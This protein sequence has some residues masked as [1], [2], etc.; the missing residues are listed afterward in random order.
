MLPV[1]ALKFN[2]T[3]PEAFNFITVKM[4]SNAYIMAIWVVEFSNGVY[5]IR[6]CKVDFFIVP[7]FLMPK[8]K[9]VAQNKWKKTPIYIFSTFGSKINEFERK[10]WEKTKKFQKPKSCRQLP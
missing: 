2:A 6:V 3:N 5:K 1:S 9:S 8:L 7:L 4:Q 10:K